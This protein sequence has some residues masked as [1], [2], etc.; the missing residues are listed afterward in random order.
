MNPYPEYFADFQTTGVNRE[1]AHAPIYGTFY[2]EASAEA[3][4]K[5]PS[6]YTLNLDGE[7]KFQL[8]ES[9]NAPCM[10]AGRGR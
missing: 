9:P 10:A 3:Y 6:N 4:R 5:T 2:D 8:F 1:P 7:W